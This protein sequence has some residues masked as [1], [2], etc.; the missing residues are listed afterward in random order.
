MQAYI[1]KIREQSEIAR[2]KAEQEATEARQKQ[3]VEYEKRKVEEE[4][5][6]RK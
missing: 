5:N 1:K 3:W 2:R 4:E 6:R